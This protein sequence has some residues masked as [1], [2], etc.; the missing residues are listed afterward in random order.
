MS[1]TR[2][3]NQ[4]RSYQINLPGNERQYV[5]QDFLENYTTVSSDGS[6]IAMIVSRYLN[7][8][9][10]T[11]IQ[12]SSLTAS[13]NRFSSLGEEICFYNANYR[14]LDDYFSLAL[15]SNG[16][17]MAFGRKYHNIINATKVD[18]EIHEYKNEKWVRK[19]I[20]YSDVNR[21][22]V[23]SVQ[24]ILF[25]PNGR[26]LAILGYGIFR[27]KEVYSLF[28]FERGDGSWRQIGTNV[29]RGLSDLFSPKSLS[30][31]ENGNI[32]AVSGLAK[33]SSGKEGIIRVFSYKKMVGWKR[34]GLDIESEA[35]FYGRG[36][37][38][39]LGSDGESIVVMTNNNFLSGS[40][41]TLYTYTNKH[42]W[43]RV[44]D[45]ILSLTP[46]RESSSIMYLSTGRFKVY[47]F[48]CYEEIQNKNKMVH[49]LYYEHST[50]SWKE[51]NSGQSLSPY[52]SNFV[53]GDCSSVKPLK[54]EKMAFIT[55]GRSHN[56]HDLSNSSTKRFL[57]KSL[58]S[59]PQVSV[60]TEQ[61]VD[62]EE[63]FC[64][65]AMQ[66]E[67]CSYYNVKSLCAKSCN[68]CGADKISKS[69][70]KTKP[71]TKT[72]D[73]CKDNEE[74]SY[75][76]HKCTYI[77]F[78]IHFISSCAELQMYYFSVH[79]QLLFM[80]NCPKSCNTCSISR[81]SNSTL[82]SKKFTTTSPN[83]TSKS[84]AMIHSYEQKPKPTLTD[85]I[86]V[87]PTAVP[88][89]SPS[90]VPSKS[91]LAVPSKSPSAVPSKSPFISSPIYHKSEKSFTSFSAVSSKNCYDNPWFSSKGYAC[92]SILFFKHFITSCEYLHEFNFNEYQKSLFIQNCPKSCES[93]S[94]SKRSESSPTPSQSV[95]SNIKKNSNQQVVSISNIS[96]TS[97]PEAKIFSSNKYPS[98][99]SSYH[100]K[101]KEVFYKGFSCKSIGFLMQY[102]DSCKQLPKEL[103]LDLNDIYFFIDKCPVVCKSCVRVK[104]NP[105]QSHALGGHTSS[106][107]TSSPPTMNLQ[108]TISKTLRPSWLPQSDLPYTLTPKQVKMV[109]KT[110]RNSTFI[111]SEHPT[112][113]SRPEVAHGYSSQKNT[114][115]SKAPHQTKMLG[116]F[117][118]GTITFIISLFFVI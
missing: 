6:T 9:I 27:K 117:V 81:N 42:E 17:S 109:G 32:I 67:I 25:A 108:P 58:E 72:I 75:R 63:A 93:C 35:A 89:K 110:G 83:F 116:N 43:Q 33:H 56:F 18:I 40:S 101:D 28:V 91:P 60:I 107:I 38:F 54:N 104:H 31:S 4:F 7:N 10:E 39:S 87:S 100:C 88:S 74:F 52:E 82:Q 112:D 98:S 76:G 62:V 96:P 11:C 44:N 30:F 37:L 1:E 92:N 105:K 22:T 41:I 15:S 2:N 84:L 59:E 78:L 16:S 13:S 71:S 70:G 23:I 115:T 95:S 66:M 57:S 106:E 113:D 48:Q 26:R 46:L 50:K 99:N 5:E 111:S 77:S 36:N 114:H 12:A 34:M 80:Q 64:K 90:A 85:D 61:C 8:K 65:I 29:L 45:A 68:V 3:T 19:K 24:N 49:L 69:R 103:G 20:Q 14:S 118:I 47:A 97:A 21:P 94:T 55:L 51:I 73:N 86:S 79:E 102:F 53:G